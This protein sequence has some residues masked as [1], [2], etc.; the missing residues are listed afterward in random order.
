MT[1]KAT[2]ALLPLLYD[3][4]RPRGTMTGVLSENMA[5]NHLILISL[6]SRETADMRWEG[7]RQTWGGEEQG[8]GP[9]W[10]AANRNELCA[11]IRA[12]KCLTLTCTCKHAHTLRA[13][14]TQAAWRSAVLSL[15]CTV[16]HNMTRHE[17]SLH[18]TLM[19]S[20]ECYVLN[21]IASIYC[22][23]SPE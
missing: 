4:Q 11:P 19:D 8:R 16:P 7:R 23:K 22:I 18:F 1:V 14:Y 17:T 20:L 10:C 5:A 6:W 3:W 9:S 2:V 12:F 13:T 15:F 21:L